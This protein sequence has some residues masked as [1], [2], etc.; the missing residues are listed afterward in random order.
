M[1][2][3]DFNSIDYDNV[4]ES[5]KENGFVVIENLFNKSYCDNL[6]ERTINAFQ[7]INPELNHKDPN[8]WLKPQLPPQ[9]RTGMFQSLISNINPV[10]EVRRK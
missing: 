1:Q 9:T 2:T 8:K 7:T 5:I 4:T 10:R 3:F 6:V